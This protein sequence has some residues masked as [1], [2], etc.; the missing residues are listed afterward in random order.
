MGGNGTGNKAGMPGSEADSPMSGQGA[1]RPDH[2]ERDG[3]DVASTAAH[4]TGRSRAEALRAFDLEAFIRAARET[5]GVVPLSALP[6]VADL[7]PADA[8]AEAADSPLRWHAEGEMRKVLRRRS[9]FLPASSAAARPARGE[10]D[11]AEKTVGAF[12]AT[13]PHLTVTIEGAV[14]LECQRCMQPFSWPVSVEAGYRVARD[15]RQADSLAGDDAED[16]VIVGSADFDLLDLIDEEI[17]LSLPMVPKHRVCPAVHASVVSGAD[18]ALGVDRVEDIDARLA[19][20]AGDDP[21][22][23]PGERVDIS[24]AS[25]DVAD[26]ADASAVPQAGKA[27]GKPGAI[28]GGASASG[29]TRKPFASALAG[30][31]AAAGDKSESVDRGQ[32]DQGSDTSDPSGKN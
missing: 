27:R 17:V 2:A 28:K 26:D 6:R 3:G 23:L 1:D 21:T 29:P 10:G 20:A 25:P 14:W 8:P 22:P 16:D 30:W 5:R 19:D 9:G 31:K 4:G 13:E 15:E 24:A 12:Q 7:M 18:G 32:S 11:S